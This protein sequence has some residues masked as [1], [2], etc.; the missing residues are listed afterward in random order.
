MRTRFEE[1]YL[2]TVFLEYIEGEVF[3]QTH[4]LIRR[5]HQGVSLQPFYVPLLDDGILEVG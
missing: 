4:R 5:T 2:T 3:W 1:N